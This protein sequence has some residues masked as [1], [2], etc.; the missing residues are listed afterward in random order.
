MSYNQ[1]NSDIWVTEHI[2]PYDIFH[3]GITKVFI[4]R[5]TKFQNMAIVESGPN[6]KALV[7][8]GKWQSCVGDEFTYH[9]PLVHPACIFHGDPKNI[10]ILG[11]GEGATIREALKWNNLE[12]VT[13]VDLD[14]EVV[15]AC[16]E[17]LGEIH[18]GAFDDH[19]LHLHIIDA[20]EFIEKTDMLWDVV[21]SDLSDP[22]EGGP[23]SKLFTKDFF[24]R[25]KK[26]LSSQ[27]I[28]TVQAGPTGPMELELH[29]RLINTLRTVFP[30]TH[31]YTSYT[32]SF[33]SPWGFGIASNNLIT[34]PI[35][36]KDIDTVLI[37]KTTANFKMIDGVSLLGMFSTPKFLR[38]AIADQF[39]K[40]LCQKLH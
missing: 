18:Q 26:I 38:D 37:K 1:I 3:H 40:S 2:S 32:P 34:L 17:H 22:V 39:D 11:G 23:S 16:K 4:H 8:D 35:N 10:L 14:G 15:E 20:F 31:S 6:G 25:I 12:N 33:V 30:Y 29:V 28:F 5:Q 9:E 24:E 13:M 19:R 21:I 36:P 7:L 27:G